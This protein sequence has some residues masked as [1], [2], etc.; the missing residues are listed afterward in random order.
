LQKEIKMQPVKKNFVGSTPKLG[1]QFTAGKPERQERDGSQN[2]KSVTAVSVG[3]MPTRAASGTDHSGSTSAVGAAKETLR[4]VRGGSSPTAQQPST[5]AKIEQRFYQSPGLRKQ[6]SP[7]PM[8]EESATPVRQR[9]TLVKV[10]ELGAKFEG[11]EVERD[12]KKYLRILSSAVSQYLF[13]SQDP[14]KMRA[15]LELRAKT[16][17]IQ[18]ARLPDAAKL[19]FF[20]VEKK[21]EDSEEEVRDNDEGKAQK[22]KERPEGCK[23]REGESEQPGDNHLSTGYQGFR[24]PSDNDSFGAKGGSE[25]DNDGSNEEFGDSSTQA[26][27]AAAVGRPGP[28]SAGSNRG[29][30]LVLVQK[31]DMQ[32][33]EDLSTET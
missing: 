21:E 19:E 5:G 26:S 12:G 25:E 2:A 4:G 10:V 6:P 27:P 18:D 15:F 32:H 8:P 29:G 9:A 16:V 30:S 33:E 3:N 22:N 28:S 31:S 11:H 13:E 20:E 24:L 23:T 14:D 1:Q 7:T 17:C